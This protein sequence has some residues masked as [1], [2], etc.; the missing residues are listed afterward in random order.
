MA[1]NMADFSTLGATLF[2]W[3]GKIW[4]AINL[5]PTWRRSLSVFQGY[6]KSMVFSSEE[7]KHY[8]NNSNL[9]F[10]TIPIP[11]ESSLS[12]PILEEP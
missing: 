3:H 12:L 6:D 1:K 10:K 8:Q 9:Q 2:P 7:K 4:L 11:F 5:A